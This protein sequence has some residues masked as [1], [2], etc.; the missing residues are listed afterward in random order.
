MRFCKIGFNI[1]IFCI[2]TTIS[3]FLRVNITPSANQKV[4]ASVNFLDEM[5][6][7]NK[8]IFNVNIESKI[9]GTIKEFFIEDGQK[10]SPV[11]TYEISKNN[12]VI[13][14]N[15]NSKDFSIDNVKLGVTIVKN[16]VEGLVKSIALLNGKNTSF[17]S[18]Q[19]INDPVLLYHDQDKI[20]I[21]IEIYDPWDTLKN[22]QS[23]VVYP[24]IIKDFE[25]NFEKK[26]VTVG[27][28]LKQFVYVSFKGFKEN[29]VLK[30]N[31]NLLF[32]RSMNDVS[33]KAVNKTFFY[34]FDL[35]NIVL[36][37]KS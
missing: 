23:I 15:H 16:R 33:L 6:G 18:G 19:V 1:F 20:N 5:S 11:S 3:I 22:V 34:N 21:A 17:K 37:I 28:K 35:N 32:Q 8:F 26:Y 29:Q 30:F 13:V 14:V 4:K 9:D 2:L 10:L 7:G 12:Y 36:D 27:G 24:E 25:V 31:I